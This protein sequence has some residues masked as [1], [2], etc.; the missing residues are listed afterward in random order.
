MSISVKDVPE[1]ITN[2]ISWKVEEVLSDMG[3]KL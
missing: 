3:N 2:S 1:M